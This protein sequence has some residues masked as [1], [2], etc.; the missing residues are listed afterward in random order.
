VFQL[1]VPANQVP[2]NIAFGLEEMTMRKFGIALVSG[3]SVALL[4]AQA[5]AQVDTQRPAPGPNSMPSAHR[6]AALKK[7]TDGIKFESDRYVNCMT[8]EGENP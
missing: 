3:L 1:L 4:A 6:M 5:F 2:E 7:C 8:A